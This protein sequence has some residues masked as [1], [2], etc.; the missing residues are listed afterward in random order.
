MGYN[1]NSK[2]Q[3]DSTGGNIPQGRLDIEVFAIKENLVQIFQ[4]LG[5]VMPHTGIKQIEP[6]KLISLRGW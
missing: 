3:A 6:D 1:I 5:A 2:I 4:G